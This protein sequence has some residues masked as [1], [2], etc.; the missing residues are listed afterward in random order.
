MRHFITLF[1]YDSQKIYTN[2]K[3]HGTLIEF[4]AFVS[5]FLVTLVQ[6]LISRLIRDLV[7]GLRNERLLLRPIVSLPRALEMLQ[8]GMGV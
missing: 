7:G 8:M 5:H 1:N 2:C 4:F 3:L 6:L